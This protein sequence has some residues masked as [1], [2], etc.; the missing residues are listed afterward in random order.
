MN[1]HLDA[2]S[3]I[4]SFSGM[5]ADLDSVGHM[6]TFFNSFGANSFYADFMDVNADFRSNYLMNSMLV[7]LDSNTYFVFFCLNTR[8]ESPI[9][10]SRLRKLSL[11]NDNI[12]FYGFGINSSYLNLPIM[13]YGNSVNKLIDILNFKSELCRDL[14][15]KSYNYSIF[16]LEDVK[17]DGY[18]FFFGLSFFQFYKGSYLLDVFKT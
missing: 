11:L 15:F 12:K 16:N 17:R 4:L 8:L 6:K 1:E 7:N 10:N 18:M 13:L 14:L 9:L 3:S 5:L 2:D